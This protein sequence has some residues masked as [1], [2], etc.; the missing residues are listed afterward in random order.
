MAHR[1]LTARALPALFAVALAATFTA[2]SGTAQAAPTW[3]PAATASIHPGVMLVTDGAQCTANFIY[4]DG[5][6][7]YIGQAAHCSGTDGNTAT[8]GCTAHSLPVGTPVQIDGATRPGTLVYNSWLTMQA[9]G[10]KDADTCQYNDLALVQVDP[11]DVADVNP[12]VPSFGGPIGLNTTGTSSGEKVSSYGNS[13]LRLGL[14]PL[15]PKTGISLG[16]S[17]GGWNHTVYTVTP[18]IPGD[19]GS[20]FLD[21][22][23]RAFGVLST[24]AIAPLAGSNGVGDLSRELAY[25]HAHSSFGAVNLVPGTEPFVPAL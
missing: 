15:S 12:S 19:S 16:D 23:G 18:G 17:N 10:E 14:S 7:V 6:N 9:L 1:R 24:V 20:G 4:S 25:M 13:S 11:A 8:N 21:S 22:Q 5:S 2:L 3:A